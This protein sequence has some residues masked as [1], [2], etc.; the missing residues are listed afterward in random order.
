[1]IY[2]LHIEPPYKH[3]AHY[4]GFTENGD[5]EQRIAKHLQGKASP[6]IKA[7]IEH[8]HKVELALVLEG[9]RALERRL[10]RRGGH[11]HSICPRCRPAYLANRR[12]IAASKEGHPPSGPK[13][14]E[15]NADVRR[16]M[17]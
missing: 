10:K 4:I 8:G 16:S 12:A 13:R 3:A 5:V 9:D 1:M 2:V 15:R 11:G 6:L 14:K 17:G 7:A